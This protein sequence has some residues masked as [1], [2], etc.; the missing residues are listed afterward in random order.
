[1]DNNEILTP[2]INK[3]INELTEYVKEKNKY[4]SAIEKAERQAK[5]AL[6]TATNAAKENTR[7]WNVDSTIKHLQQSSLDLA[8]A[9]LG[10]SEAQK[11]AFE[12]T[13]TAVLN[14]LGA[15]AID[16]LNTALGDL[17]VYIEQKIESTVK[18]YKKV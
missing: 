4:I 15:E 18:V 2:E 17:N 3:K 14:I 11:K 6:R 1:M 13:K 7:I 9:I 12:D 5:V 16:Y 8:K 10:Q